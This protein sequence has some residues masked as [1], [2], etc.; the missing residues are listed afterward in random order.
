ML[1]YV[2]LVCLLADSILIGLLI[3]MGYCI[4]F[5]LP[6]SQKFSE[7]IIFGNFGNLRIFP[8]YSLR[9]LNGAIE[10]L[11]T[12]SEKDEPGVSAVSKINFRNLSEA[13][14]FENLC[15]RKFPAIQ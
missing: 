7:D 6:Y 13:I 1:F 11:K 12:C 4:Q 2:F 10:V 3:Q 15:L 8:N 9:K 14:F 5:V